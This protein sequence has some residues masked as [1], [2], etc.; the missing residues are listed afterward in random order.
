MNSDGTQSA[1]E[2]GVYYP[3]KNTSYGGSPNSGVSGFVAVDYY[4]GVRVAVYAS[5]AFWYMNSAW[6]K[7]ITGPGSQDT[8]NLSSSQLVNTLFLTETIT[9]KTNV[10]PV[11]QQVSSVSLDPLVSTPVALNLAA[12]T[13]T[14]G[15][16]LT[17]RIDTVPN[18]VRILKN[19]NSLNAGESISVA[20]FTSLTATYSKS[21]LTTLG[22]LSF[23]VTDGKGGSTSSFVDFSLK[24][25]IVK[26]VVKNGDDG[27]NKLEGTTGDDEIFA[28][29]GKDIILASAGNDKIDG[30]TGIDTLIF[31]TTS[32][33][34]SFSHN[35]DGSVK[36]TIGSSAHTLVN[37]ERVQFSGKSYALDLE[38]NAGDAAKLIVTAF[39]SSLIKDYLGIGISIIDGG[40]DLL[41]LNEQ[42]LSLGMLPAQNSKFID[43]LFT[44][45]AGRAPNQLES[46]YFKGLLDNGTYSQSSLLYAA[47]TSSSVT[48]IIN[49]VSLGGVALEYT[50]SIF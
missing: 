11:A 27:N 46:F 21:A 44:N 5:G 41:K 2:N 25:T 23:T 37:V 38:G 32:S 29:G 19:G 42:V 20:D 9:T 43:L 48:G 10:P 36:L 18:G 22:Q 4:N 40:T 33:G 12:P 13:D 28:G 34:A 17:I 14:N 50:P 30:G 35:S 31:S 3:L 47:E 6:A 24:G 49:Q 39:G 7:D 15:D 45:L 26:G 16:A 1:L 8:G